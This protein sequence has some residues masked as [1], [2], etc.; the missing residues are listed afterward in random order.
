MYYLFYNE[1][2]YV[3]LW[4]D[5][6]GNL[7]Y[8][9]EHVAD[10]MF[11]SKEEPDVFAIDVALSY[12]KWDDEAIYYGDGKKIEFSTPVIG[13]IR[14]LN[15]WATRPLVY[16]LFQMFAYE[17]P[18]TESSPLAPADAESTSQDPER[19]PDQNPSQG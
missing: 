13:V 14:K 15:P 16:L 8:S 5:K 19:D 6:R 9:V 1:D 7:L 3:K 18:I 2:S 12:L 4:K 11:F 10:P 17:S